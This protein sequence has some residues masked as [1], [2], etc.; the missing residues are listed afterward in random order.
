M[1]MIEVT[2]SCG[3]V[4]RAGAEHAGKVARCPRCGGSVAMPGAIEARRSDYRG[5]RPARARSWSEDESTERMEAVAPPGAA[6]GW[7]A[8][9]AGLVSAAAVGVLFVPA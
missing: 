2:C 7:A 3:A 5:G 6:L 8:L 4:L 9:I 1:S